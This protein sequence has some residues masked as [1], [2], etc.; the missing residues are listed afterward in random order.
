[1]TTKTRTETPAWQ[2]REA[3]SW[4]TRHTEQRAENDEARGREGGRESESRPRRN[5][6]QEFLILFI[7]KTKANE[8]DSG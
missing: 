5:R 4:G 7:L 1:M 3:G 2:V 6:P 8:D